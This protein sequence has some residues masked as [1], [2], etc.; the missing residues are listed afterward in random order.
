MPGLE[1]LTKLSVMPSSNLASK[2]EGKKINKKKVK[3]N[4]LRYWQELS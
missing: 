1:G 4:V 3:K 2:K